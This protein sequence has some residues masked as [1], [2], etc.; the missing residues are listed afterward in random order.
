MGYEGSPRP[1]AGQNL[2]ERGSYMSKAEALQV[3]GECVHHWILESPRG[4]LTP[5][6]CKKCGKEKEFTGETSYRI[7][8]GS[9]HR[10]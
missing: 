6:R 8:R 2:V 9:A 1:A 3:V 5:G 4:E 7:G 10:S